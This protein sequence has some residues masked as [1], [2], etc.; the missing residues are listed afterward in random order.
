MID[1]EPV[2]VRKGITI[3]DAA[4]Q[5][6]IYIPTLCYLENLKSYGG[7]RL[8]IVE[9]KG[10]KGY[11]TACTTPLEPG[12]E[13]LTRTDA[14]QSLRRNILEMTLSEHPYTCLVC[15]DKMEC[16]EFMHTTR[17]AGTI[18]GCNFCTSNG[19]CELQD[20][21]DYLDM[22]DVRY[23]IA[24]RGIPP[25]KNNPFYDLD[26]NLCVLCGRCVRICNEERNSRVLAF[27][28]RGN[29]TIV[30]TAFNESQADAG[31]E[32]CGAC[33]DVCPTG[34]IS[35]K[36]GKWAGLPDR[37]TATTCTLCS[38]GCTMNVNT[39]G[40][41][42]VN[43]GPPPGHRTNPPQ[44]CIRGKFLSGDI[45]H[46]PS[47]ITNPLI[48]RNG[49][50]VEV[51]W[52]E[53]LSYTAQK[54]NQYRGNGFGIIGSA[55]D[56]LEENYSLQKF[57]RKTMHSNNIDLFASYPDGELAGD[58]HALLPPLFRPDSMEILSADT[59]LLIG[60]DASISHP[61]VENRIRKAFDLGKNILY[62]NACSTRTSSFATH[63]IHYAAG[64]EYHFLYLL[65]GSLIKKD[66]TTLQGGLAKPFKASDMALAAKLCRI[67]END[68][69]PFA[70]AMSRSRKLCIIAGDELFRTTMAGNS[71]R[72][73]SNIP[74]LKS[75]KGTCRIILLGNEGNLYGGALAGAHPDYL[76][77]FDPVSD[78][79]AIKIWNKRWDA[80]LSMERGI[81]R[82]DMSGN[83]GKD[84]IRALMIAGDMPPHR[85][86]SKLKF[87][88]QMN[89]FRT[90]LSEY[91]HVFLPVTGFLENGGHFLAL[92]GKPKR[93]KRTVAA[94]G[95]TRTI[96]SILSGL[97]AEMDGTGFASGTG[98]IWKELQSFIPFSVK[99]GGGK[100]HVFIPIKP[101]N[102]KGNMQ[103][104]K[105]TGCNYDYYRY[106]GNRLVSLVPDLQVILKGSM[107]EKV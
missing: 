80:G 16:T 10:G 4:R 54:L 96:P 56:S 1:G 81:S 15:K 55:Q 45:M 75:G 32:F 98:T 52:E 66:G 95:K 38:I 37:S 2:R 102:P 47:R 23:P 36:M 43:V 9:I 11:P 31:C 62:A 41:R 19:D 73:L 18:T 60:T 84:G 8:C 91:A 101:E 79:K 71:L 72:A 82:H 90:P 76:P 33:V 86:F 28:Q 85:Q 51:K 93:L 78:Q 63:E 64:E 87:L 107:P 104:H 59:I 97:A 7:C 5:A 48:R 3:L 13:V 26:Y 22:K 103:K 88:V 17:K 58:I 83:I 94:P 61:L 74:Y 12:M 106:R 35:E 34:S 92:D 99:N 70:D 6:G 25:E 68:L 49:K 42:I 69:E 20:L 40:S 89:M 29:S 65:N 46:H 14:L 27:V 53:A 24:Y 100:E 30:G 105:S 77:G 39:R 21:I 67:S 50:W 44:L 57:S